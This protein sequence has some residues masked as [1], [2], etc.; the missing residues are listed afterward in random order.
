MTGFVPRLVHSLSRPDVMFVLTQSPQLYIYIYFAGGCPF[1]SFSSL[2]EV[3]FVHSTSRSRADPGP[4]VP[5]RDLSSTEPGDCRR[6][7]SPCCTRISMLYRGDGWSE[8]RDETEWAVLRVCRDASSGTPSRGV[9]RLGD[10]A[11]DGPKL[12]PRPR[13]VD[14]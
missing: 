8:R 4:A 9:P 13:A 6:P 7:C 11:R 12:S 5:P 1:F 2:L 10:R 3:S 14:L